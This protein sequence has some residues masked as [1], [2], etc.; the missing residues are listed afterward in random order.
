MDTSRVRN[1]YKQALIDTHMGI[2]NHKV[3]QPFENL[4]LLILTKMRQL[5]LD[6]ELT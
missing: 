6:C 3:M 4:N 5:L 1:S 2:L